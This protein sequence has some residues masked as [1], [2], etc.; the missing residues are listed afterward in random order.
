M[1][2]MLRQPLFGNPSFTN[3]NDAPLGV[4]G[5]NKGCAFARLGCTR[6]K[7]MW[8][9]ETNEWKSLFKLRMHFHASNRSGK[10]II[11]DN[12]P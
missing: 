1:A 4:S 7:D 8:N 10:D 3:T 9:Q 2:E 12:I 11:T 6:V 5:Q